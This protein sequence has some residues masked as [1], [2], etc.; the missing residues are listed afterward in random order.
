MGL[1]DFMKIFY[2]NSLQ[3]Y[4]SQCAVRMDTV[5]T[6]SASVKSAGPDQLAKVLFV[7]RVGQMENV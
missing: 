4:V 6:A 5:I 1:L 7:R 3:K 2:E